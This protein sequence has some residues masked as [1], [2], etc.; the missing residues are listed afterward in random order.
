LPDQTNPEADLKTPQEKAS[1]RLNLAVW[2]RTER[3]IR[4]SYCLLYLL[5]ASLATL[6]AR[7]NRGQLSHLLPEDDPYQGYLTEC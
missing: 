4:S 3:F 2:S 7:K 1:S 6:S 5:V